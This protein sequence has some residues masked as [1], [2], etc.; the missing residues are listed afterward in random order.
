M[1]LTVGGYG[2]NPAVHFI[3]S[4]IQE[5]VDEVIKNKGWKEKASKAI[6]NTRIVYITN[7]LYSHRGSRDK[8]TMP[9]IYNYQKELFSLWIDK[10]GRSYTLA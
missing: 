5:R 2:G 6:V 10:I 1:Y 9:D 7:T 4:K 3:L 8:A